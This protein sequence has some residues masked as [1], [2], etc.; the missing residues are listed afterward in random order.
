LITERE[1]YRVSQDT[2]KLKR[3]KLHE[4]I[5]LLNHVFE[6]ARRNAE[7]ADFLS[8]QIATL[9]AASNSDAYQATSSM[10]NM[11]RPGGPVPGERP[12]VP[13][14]KPSQSTIQLLAAFPDPPGSVH[15]SIQNRHIDTVNESTGG[16][17]PRMT[18][19]KE[20]K[21]SEGVTLN[22]TNERRTRFP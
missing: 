22:H 19:I 20:E 17:L 8:S 15:Q 13:T 5:E 3:A 10:E 18:R 2:L 21:Q 11:P 1:E 14:N 4:I 9:Q 6:E 12:Y 7:T 16:A